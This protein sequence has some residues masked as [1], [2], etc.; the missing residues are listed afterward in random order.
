MFWELFFGSLGRHSA[1]WGL[2]FGHFRAAQRVFEAIF[3]QF[4][5]A[6]RVFG[7]TFA[8]TVGR[9]SLCLGLLLAQIKAASPVEK[10]ESFKPAFSKACLVMRFFLLKGNADMQLPIVPIPGWLLHC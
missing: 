2:F 6:Q 4:R 9:R 10:P 3:L 1:S 8:G 5:A 7:A